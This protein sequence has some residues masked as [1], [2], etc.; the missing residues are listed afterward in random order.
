[1]TNNKLDIRLT[2][3]DRT[4]YGVYKQDEDYIFTCSYLVEKSL[5]LVILDLNGKSVLSE[6]IREYKIAGN[7]YSVRISGLN[8]NKFNYYYVCDG[9]I[10]LDPYMRG[11]NHKR[12]FGV[13]FEDAFKDNPNEIQ[14]TS[15]YTV[16]SYDFSDDKRPCICQSDVI[17]YQLH[18]RGFTKHSSSKV[19]GRGCFL[20]IIEKIP[21]LLDLKVNQIEIM[22]SYDFY[23]FDLPDSYFANHPAYASELTIDKD[24]K[25]IENKPKQKLNYWGYKKANYFCP[26]YEYSYSSDAIT[27]FKDMVCALHKAGIEV[28]MQ[29]FYPKDIKASVVIDSLRYWYT[30]YHVD[31]FHVMGERLPVELILSD[32]ILYYSKL[33]INGI[34]RDDD[35]ISGL[36]RDRNV[37]DVNDGFM[38]AMRKYLKS[39][40]DSLEGFIYSNRL[41]SPVNRT[42]NYL[43]KYEG[44]TLNDLVSYEHKHN[45]AN[46]ENNL[47]GT[48]YNLSWNCGVEG[49]STKKAVKELRIKQIKN[50]LC[51]LF[52][53]QGTPM[54]FMGDE[55]MNSQDGNNNPYCQDNETTWLNWKLNKS[56]SEILEFTKMLVTYRSSHKVLHQNV[57]LKNMDYL[58][59]GWPDISYHQDMAWKSSFNNYLLHIGVMLCGKYATNEVKS[60][61]D[62]HKCVSDDTIYVAYNMHWENHMF[63]LPR[64][65]SGKKWSLVFAT[66][67]DTEVK[68]INADL[69][70]S[71]EEICIFKRSIVVL[72]AADSIVKEEK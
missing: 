49:K 54:L 20:G 50:A 22:P 45:E 58:Q 21:Y 34:N 5:K 68:E 13:C 23:E 11:H 60:N 27:E 18:V 33:Y 36:T 25:Q 31:G 72:C 29:M 52:L 43:T 26:K 47:D 32:D 28:I 39:D 10:S 67:D 8:L 70:E 41:N 4:E 16:D 17:A 1:M 19:K 57:E 61:D 6:D 9:K 69:I 55:F 15:T 35:L 71:Q 30:E 62:V 14:N 53:A 64:L 2:K 46:G 59:Q 3:S 56:S 7:V 44:F 63:G 66:C 65:K 38:M 40:S 51:L 12:E 42:I 48:A 24:G 37:I